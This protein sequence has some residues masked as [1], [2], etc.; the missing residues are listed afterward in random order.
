MSKSTDSKKKYSR[1]IFIFRRDLRLVDNTALNKAASECDEVLPVFI[2][3]K[4]QVS[5][6]ENKYF[7]ENA[8]A[9]MLASLREVQDE[10]EK[11]G[12]V[13]CVGEGIYEEALQKIL[14]SYKPEAVYA[15]RDYTP[16]ARARDEKIAKMLEKNHIQFHLCDDYTLSPIEDIRTHT[17]NIYSVFTPFM[18]SAQM[19]E[20]KKP[21]QHQHHFA[22]GFH[23]PGS[24]P[25]LYEKQSIAQK[26]GRKKALEV[27]TH[28][29]NLRDY[30][31][32]R[33]IPSI[34]GTSRLSAHHKFGTISIRESYHEALKAKVHPHFI[35]ELYWRDFYYYI[36][37]HFPQVFSSSFQGWGDAIEWR[38][39][40][41]EFDAWKAGKTGVPFVD[42][43]MRELNE[44]GWMHNR[45][46][47]ITASYLT[48]SLLIDWRWGEKYFAEKLVDYD[49]AQNNGGWQWSASLGAD[50][51]PMRIFNPALQA[52]EYDSDALYIKKWIPELADLDAK[53]LTDGESRDYSEYEKTYPPPIVDRKESFARAQEVYARAKQKTR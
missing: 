42:A 46:R 17:G 25:D 50:P 7:S 16:F 34:E 11:Q 45:V 9:F 35:S 33:N 30:K 41:K 29:E 15:N 43:G 12:G 32:T 44:T 49:P 51:K 37:F 22:R 53:L 10:I 4:Q 31:D 14:L 18:K 47:M 13:L 19:H 2:F 3:D 6:K 38:N 39:N 48:K 21:I 24:I 52:K 5:K 40:E 36:A 1:G 28:F 8:F 27:V 23:S 20:V 26:G